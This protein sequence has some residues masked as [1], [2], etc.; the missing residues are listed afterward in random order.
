[1]FVRAAACGAVAVLVFVSP[2]ARA[3]E[4]RALHALTVLD[5]VSPEE[6]GLE[7]RVVHLGGPALVVRNETDRT[8]EVF[9]RRATP[10]LRISSSGVEMNAGSAFAYRSINPDND[11]VPGNVGNGPRVRWVNVST[12]ST[13][14]WFDPRLIFSNEGS[15]SV[16]M[17]L[18]NENVI[19]QGGFESLH[20][21]GHFRSV[22]DPPS[23]AGLELRLAEGPV[24]VLFARNE[25]GEVLLVRGRNDEPMLRIGPA[26]V[27]ANLRSPSFYTSAAQT[28]ARVPRTANANAPPRWESLSSQPV[29]AWLEYRAAVP[30]EMQQR[31]ELGTARATI[32]EWDSP[33]ELGGRPI[34][35][36]GAVE[37]L[38]PATPAANPST[39]S[40]LLPWWIATALMV[41]A[42]L[43]FSTRRRN[44]AV[45]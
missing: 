1:M 27:E 25:T 30:P 8:L 4:E 34:D 21:H 2:P 20:G 28:I 37:W 43:A 39:T 36:G 29:W 33:M 41:A 10:F 12:D 42:G 6:P 11:V 44:A 32:V 18:G 23:I 40:N 16:P 31:E 35:V 9:D 15:W 14:T 5:A 13:W 3:H 24:P 45:A 19:A 7:V 38:P 26:G 17:R 22:L